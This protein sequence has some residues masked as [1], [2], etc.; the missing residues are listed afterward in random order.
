MIL[1]VH[2][3]FIRFSI[4][5]KPGYAGEQGYREANRNIR[6]ILNLV[7]PLVK[8]GLR[9]TLKPGKPPPRRSS[10]VFLGFLQS[11]GII[12]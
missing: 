10:L 12:L 6:N 5:L 1:G 2:K 11:W 8:P 9:Y 4:K 7:L 3:R